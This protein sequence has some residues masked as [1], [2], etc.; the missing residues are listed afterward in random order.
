MRYEAKPEWEP[1]L[2]SPS[3]NRDPEPASR[4]E[5]IRLLVVDDH[6]VVRAGLR[7]LLEAYPEIAIVGEAGTQ[8]E[9]INEAVRLDPDVILM[10]IRLPNG[11]GIE[12]CRGIRRACPKTRVLFLTSFNEEKALISSIAAGAD[13]YMLKEADEAALVQAIRAVASGKAVLDPAVTHTALARMRAAPHLYEPDQVE[14]LSAREEQILTL[15]LK[16]QTNH[17]IGVTLGLSEKTVR[18]YLTV[19]FEK[20]HVSHRTQLL[21]R[22]AQPS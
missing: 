16:G 4:A 10:D 20:L 18:N 6:Q 22:Y 7:T 21:A 9:A 8:A 3:R 19:V 14:P 11:N 17:E 1:V 15:L 13:G 12:A 5:S 2:S